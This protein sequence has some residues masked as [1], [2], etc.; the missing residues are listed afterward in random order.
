MVNIG[1]VIP[2]PL[3]AGMALPDIARL[4]RT[5]ETVGLDGIWAEDGLASGDAAVLDLMCVLAACAAAS[6]KIEVGSAIFAPS[7]RNLS[8]ALKQ[9]ATLQLLARGRLQLGVALG[10]AGDEVYELAGLTRSG[11]RNR[12]DEFL[13]I[14]GAARRGELERMPSPLSSQALLLGTA[15]AVPPVWVG[16]TS[17]AA[18]AV[19]P[20]TGTAGCPTYKP[21]RSSRLP[22]AAYASWRRSKAVRP[23]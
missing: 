18:F 8:W 7:L 6:Q 14:L 19:R 1:V 13:G 12:T 5:A 11:Q 22:R 3:P 2:N 23:H 21:R 15:L 10:A 17:E 9:V 20:T 16:G 4:A